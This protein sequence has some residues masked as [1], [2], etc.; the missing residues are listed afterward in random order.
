SH[1]HCRAW[2]RLR[3]GLRSVSSEKNWELDPIDSPIAINADAHRILGRDHMANGR[4]D[5]TQKEFEPAIH[6]VAQF[7]RK[8]LQS[9][10]VV[11]PS[12]QL[13]RPTRIPRGSAD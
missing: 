10:Q 1:C 8:P 7:P 5:A 4:F 3:S 9:W 12:G 2:G 13:G 6:Y 11:F